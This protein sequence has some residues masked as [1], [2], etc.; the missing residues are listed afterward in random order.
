MKGIG[1]LSSSY[2]LVDAPKENISCASVFGHWT[3]GTK[4]LTCTLQTR[5]EV[6]DHQLCFHQLLV[7]YSSRLAQ[8]SAAKTTNC[9]RLTTAPDPGWNYPVHGY[10]FLLSRLI[11]AVIVDR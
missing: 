2:C 10:L 3:H 11:L 6:F 9:H 5:I 1:P 8:D 7:S 4:Q